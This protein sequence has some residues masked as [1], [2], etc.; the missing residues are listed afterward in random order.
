M[1]EPLRMAQVEIK[2]YG[3]DARL[4][5]E[6]ISIASDEWLLYVNYFGLC[7]DNVADVLNRFPPARL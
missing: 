3:V 6:P 5:V 1:L 2:R 4:R 7:A